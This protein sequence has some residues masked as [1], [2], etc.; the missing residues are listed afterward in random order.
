VY[1]GL[2]EGEKLHEELVGTGEI[3]DRPFHP[4]VSHAQVKTLCPEKLDKDGFMNRLG[5]A[6]RTEKENG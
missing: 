6:G 1:T 3:E 2:R 5:N 4:K